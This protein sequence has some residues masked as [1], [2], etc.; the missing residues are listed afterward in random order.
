MNPT[1]RVILLASVTVLFSAGLSAPSN[2]DF[3]DSRISLFVNDRNPD[4]GER[5]KLFGTL[6]NPHRK[7]RAN[8]PVRLIRRGDGVIEVTQT[9]GDGDYSFKFRFDEGDDDGRYKA[10]YRGRDGFGYNDRHSC[11]ADSSTLRRLR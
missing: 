8:E 5:V 11:G 1:I 7:C 2:A 10:R 4:D 3:E 9:D 6:N